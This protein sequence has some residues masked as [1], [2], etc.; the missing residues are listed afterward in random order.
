MNI[1]LN[2]SNLHSGGGVQVAISVIFEL[3][4]L[5]LN[6]LEISVLVSDEVNES[7]MQLNTDF[8]KFYDYT[9]LN[10]Y[11]LSAVWK[12]VDFI[13]KKYDLVLTIFGP[14]YSI[15]KPKKMITGFAQPWIIYTKNEI[16]S[17]YSLFNKIKINVKYFFQ[18]LFFKR[19]D[20]LITELEHVKIALIEKGFTENKIEIVYNCLNSIYFSPER[21]AKE[22]VVACNNNLKFGFVGRDYPHKN[23]DFLADL[24]LILA[25]EYNLN[26]DFYVTF[27][28]LEW[29]NKSEKFR[30]LVNN[31]GALTI[32]QCPRFYKEMDAIIF[33]SL[34]ECFS[35]TPLEA[36]VMGKPLFA[37]DRH[38]VR[39][40]CKDYANY[41]NPLDPKS[42][43]DMIYKF[44]N[45]NGLKDVEKLESAKQYVLNFSNPKQR[46]QRYLDLILSFQDD[47]K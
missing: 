9:I 47:S 35:A 46:A 44:V 25:S 8:S 11:G 31:V 19:N 18:Y 42:T 12:G 40:V 14:L 38:F 2:A 37:S 39:D 22:K 30:S 10:T 28:D 23:T 17:K 5:D 41:F 1:L 15:F 36:M 32:D 4:L 13:I 16:Y 3:S 26:I 7:L 24:K 27:N 45:D 21:W 29:K 6:G 34:L 33:P 43:A 20:K